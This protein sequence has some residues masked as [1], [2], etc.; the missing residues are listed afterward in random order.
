MLLATSAGEI[1]RSRRSAAA[2]CRSS[3]VAVI[4]N[5]TGVTLLSCTFASSGC[6]NTSGSGNAT[7]AEKLEVQVT[8]NTFLGSY[9]QW[10]VSFRY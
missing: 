4:D 7:A 3:P 1:P 2:A 8:G 9:K 6:S 5:T 10:Q